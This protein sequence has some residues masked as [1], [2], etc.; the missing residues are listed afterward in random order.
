MNAD[1][2]TYRVRWSGDDESYIGT[3]AEF[4]SLSWAADNQLEA[5]KGI[6]ALVSEVLE[7]MKKTGEALPA[8]IADREYS[9]KF[10]VRIPPEAH[11]QLAIDAAE[12]SVS[13]NRLV[14]NRL[15]GS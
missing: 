2:Y 5:L 7:D 12:Q 13:L 10:M 3:V 6:R 11:R 14:S 15:V 1:H 9:G 4:R 8:A